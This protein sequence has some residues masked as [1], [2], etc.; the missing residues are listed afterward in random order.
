MI[1]TNHKLDH[2]TQARCT[3]QGL[4]SGRLLLPSCHFC[5][6]SDLIDKAAC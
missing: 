5:L 1:E 6:G 4:L 2:N 3:L